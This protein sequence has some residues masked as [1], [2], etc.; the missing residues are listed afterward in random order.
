MSGLLS[1]AATDRGRE[2]SENQDQVWVQIFSPKDGEAVGLFMVCDGV[3]GHLGGQFASHW[4][5][6]AIKS[7]FEDLFAPEETNPVAALSKGGANST[8]E[9][10]TRASELRRL[11]QSVVHAVQ[12]ANHVVY[13]HARENLDLAADASTTITLAVVLGYRAVFANVGDS[14]AYILRDGALRQITR[15]HSLVATLVASGQILP[16]EVF[17]HPQ[18]NL[19]FRS[20][21]HKNEIQVDTFIELL[22]KGDQLLLCSDGLWEMVRSESEIVRLLTQAEDPSQACQ[23][24]VDAANNAGG[25]DN[26]G[27][28]VVTV[29]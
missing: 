6:E 23:L 9:E 18:R 8:S 22:R 26:I 28:V 16:D 12:N 2:R 21:G 5:I 13:E 27:V 17:T 19:I 11:E 7:E 14:R 20:L 4:A 29:Q 15:D 1:G 3:G 25:M 10:I 24:L